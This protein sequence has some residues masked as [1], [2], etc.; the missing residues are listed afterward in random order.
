MKIQKLRLDYTRYS[1]AQLNLK[2]KNVVSSLTNNV[3]FEPTIPSLANFTILQTNFSNALDKALNGDRQLIALKNQAKEELLA[4]MRQLSFNIDAQANGDRAK[5]LSSGFDLASSSDASSVISVPTDFKIMDGMNAGELKFS[6]KKV[7]TAVSY[8]IE[9]TDE[10]PSE[11][12]LWKFQ[13]ASSREF[14]IKGLRTGIRIYGRI[15][16]V[17][18]K[19]QTANSEILSRLVQ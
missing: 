11:E 3:N 6:C 1:D 19:G 7:A 16:A 10:I 15:K 9:Y 18:T 12:T 17:G 14:T 5:L 2:A 4:G 13:P 8:V